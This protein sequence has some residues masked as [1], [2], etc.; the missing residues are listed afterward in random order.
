MSTVFCYKMKTILKQK[1]F[2]RLSKDVPALRNSFKK[3]FTSRKKFT[4]LWFLKLVNFLGKCNT[5]LKPPTFALALLPWPFNP[6]ADP[7]FLDLSTASLQFQDNYM[8][9]SF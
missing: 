8:Y 7:D 6:V 1:C 9:Y 4:I 5:Q 3:Y 2:R